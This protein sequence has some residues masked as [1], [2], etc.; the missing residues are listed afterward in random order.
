MPIYQYSCNS[1]GKRFEELRK[2]ESRHQAK[3]ECGSSATLQISKANPILFKPQF[4][5]HL[6]TK[7]VWVESKRQLK[8]ECKKRGVWAKCLD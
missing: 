7:P 5:E 8:E 2:I 6:D 4:F 3:C 1:C